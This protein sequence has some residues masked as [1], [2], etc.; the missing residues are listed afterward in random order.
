MGNTTSNQKRVVATKG[1]PHIPMTKGA[2]DIGINPANG[3]EAPFPNQVKMSLLKPGTSNTFIAKEP[4]WTTPHQVG[5][6]SEPSKA[7]FV[8]GKT[9]G[10]HIEEAKA[11]SYSTDVFAEGNGV[12]RT[13]DSTTQNHANTTGFVDGSALDGKPNADEDFLKAQCTI[14]ELTGINDAEIDPPPGVTTGKTMLARPLGYP[15]AKEPGVPPYYLEILSSSEVKFKAVRKDVTKP[16]P[17]NPT[18]W[19]KNSHTKW[20]AK[21]TGMGACDAEPLEGKDEYTLSKAMTAVSV[22]DDSLAPKNVGKGTF[23]KKETELVGEVHRKR[24]GNEDLSV[25]SKQK[26][27]VDGALDSIEAAFEYFLYWAMPTNVNVQ[28]ISC[29]G[30][31]NAQI[32][33]FPKRKVKCEV[34]FNDTVSMN[35]STNGKG[36]SAQKAMAAAR[37][38]INKLRGIEWMV[39]KFAELAKKDID[40]EFCTDMKVAVEVNFKVCAV[41]KKGYWGK[42]YTPAHVGMPWKITMTSPTLIGIGVA[43][44]ISLLNLV[45]PGVGEAAA[46]GLRRIGIKADIVFKA[47][48]KVPL[49]VSVGADEYGFWTNTGI[50]LALKPELSVAIKL[51]VSVVK[52][53]LS[54]KFP[55][56]LSAFFTVSDKPK[57]LM[58]LQPKGMLQTFFTLVIFEDSWIESKWEKEWEAVRVNWVGPKYDLFTQS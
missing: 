40:V 48:L 2:T 31:R 4:I 53:S 44:D 39:K 41:E 42:L 5:G 25:K 11:T 51:A 32:R 57:V 7:P 20:L 3:A 10:T 9:S 56:S 55:A 19:K 16:Q 54:V 37:A 34:N 38:A 52:C 33:I 12:V 22:L 21:R 13:N 36:K 6:P 43:F 26:T 50:E 28:A 8:V 27:T 45:G 30:S 15:G 49:N 35:L 24:E 1:T 17:D 14:V 18:C 58:Q 29:A 46:T 23:G 47:T